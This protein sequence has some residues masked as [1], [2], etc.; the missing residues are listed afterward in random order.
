MKL[1]GVVLVVRKLVLFEFDE[2]GRLPTASPWKPRCAGVND[3]EVSEALMVTSRKYGGH[4]LPGGKVEEK[5][6]PTDCFGDLRF[7]HR[8]I[9]A[10]AAQRELEEETGLSATRIVWLFAAPSAVESSRMVHVFYAS[11]VE[12]RVNQREEGTIPEWFE[13]GRWPEG[14]FDRFYKE[15]FPNGIGHFPETVITL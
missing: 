3:S 13:W 14:P 12:G 6:M 5:D 2:P 1:A 4:C 10:I 11:C 8:T 7:N 9:A 15:H